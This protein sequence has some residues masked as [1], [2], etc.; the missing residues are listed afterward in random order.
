LTRQQRRAEARAAAKA[1]L[2]ARIHTRIESAISVHRMWRTFYDEVLVPRGIT[3]EDPD[4]AP[5]VEWFRRSFYAG[6]ASMLD[7][8]MRV[9]PD[10]VSEDQGVEMLE[11]LREELQTF[12]KGFA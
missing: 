4:T 7:L 10:D 5:G 3:V 9:A 1:T 6:A 2:Q 8:M 12:G 11:R